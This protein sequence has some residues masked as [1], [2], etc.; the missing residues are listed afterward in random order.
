MIIDLPLPYDYLRG[1][2]K[3]GRGYVI[4]GV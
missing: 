1:S 4:A 2:G 3:D